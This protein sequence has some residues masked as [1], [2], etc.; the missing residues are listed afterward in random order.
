MRNAKRRLLAMLAG[1]IILFSIVAWAW[2]L[3]QTNNWFS[4]RWLEYQVKRSADPI[5]LQQWAINLLAKHGGDLGGYQDFY[6]TNMPSGL[7]KVKA[8]YPNV[9]IWERNEVWVFGDRKGSP[10]LVIA[11]SLPALTNH[12]ENIFPW[13]PG[14]Y[15]VR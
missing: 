10:F 5:E 1:V 11:P 9:R 15:F 4:A 2:V 14:I 12:N 7:R 8:G 6:G 3:D 13:Q